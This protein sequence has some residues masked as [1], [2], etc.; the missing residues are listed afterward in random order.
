ME[1]IASGMNE[2][3][4]AEKEAQDAEKLLLDSKKVSENKVC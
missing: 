4:T 2:N 1:R 3:L